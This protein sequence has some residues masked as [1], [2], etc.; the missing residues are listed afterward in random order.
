[1]DNAVLIQGF[2]LSDIERMVNKAVERKMADFYGRF[3]NKPPVLITR[4][5]AAKR[6]GVPLP[7]ID[8]YAKAGFLHARHIGG[9]V[10]FE[11]ELDAVKSG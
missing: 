7:T 3:C 5:D 6:V 9:R 10:F 2:T 11:E 4:K 8:A 1:M